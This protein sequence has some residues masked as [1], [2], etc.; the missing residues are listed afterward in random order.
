MESGQPSPRPREILFLG[1][2]VTTHHRPD[3]FH[4]MMRLPWAERNLRMKFTTDLTDLNPATLGAYDALFIYGNA[5]FLTTA[6]QE[7]AMEQFAN[8]GGGVAAMH[9]ACWSSPSSGK[10]TAIIGGEFLGHYAIQEFSQVI[11][12]VDHPILKGLGT[13]TSVD[14]PYQFK[15]VSPDRTI[16]TLRL[17]PGPETEMTWVRHQGQG[18][19]FYHSGGHDEQT[20]VQPNFQELVTRGIEWVVKPGDGPEISALGKA[21]IGNNGAVAVRATLA[22]TPERSAIFTRSGNRWFRPLLAGETPYETGSGSHTPGTDGPLRIGGAAEPLIALHSALTEP[23]GAVRQVLWSGRGGLPRIAAREAG[24]LSENGVALTVGTPPPG[25]AP[26]LVMNDS[27]VSVAPVFVVR[28]NEPN[29]DTVL[30]RKSGTAA[31][32]V[33]LSEGQDL[34]AEDFPWPCGDLRDVRLSL[35]GA[36]LLAARVHG[37]GGGGRI[38]T[39]SD[40]NWSTALATGTAIGGGDPVAE[41]REVRLNDAGTLAVTAALESPGGISGAILRRMAGDWEIVLRDGPQP[42]LPAGESLELPADGGSC[43]IDP[44]SNL[45][46][47]ADIAGPGGS[48]RALIHLPADGGPKLVCRTG[49]TIQPGGE[50]ITA[51]G[52]PETWTCGPAGIACGELTVSPPDG[53]DR[54]ILMRWRGRHALPLI[55]C[56]KPISTAAGEVAV[57]DFQV[58]GGGTAEDGKGGYLTYGGRWVIGTVSPDGKR[59]LIHGD[60]IHDLDGDGRDDWLEDALGGDP[61]KADGGNPLSGISGEPVGP[62][63]RFL[64]KTGAPL[65][66]SVEVSEDLETW[67]PAPAGPVESGDQTGVPA[68]YRRMELL[69]TDPGRFARVKVTAD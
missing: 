26:E 1:R 17:G 13:Y 23:G 35:N 32:E 8:A 6:A 62:R 14:E 29:L 52:A 48:S 11:L 59:R 19:V 10:I 30:V 68:G 42:W 27:G 3:L 37:A 5:F 45:W 47:L 34:G 44:G 57:A 2:Q 56:G 21:R 49:T 54:K 64:T 4:A 31:T 41:L 53:P 60:A 43:W 18:R 15:N 12:D 33:I 28:A 69:L 40:E 20:W 63:F 16:L 58:D 61:S 9:V 55:E 51:L 46:T 22:G 36:G 25:W 66:Y 65:V 24:S 7:N 50:T 39:R 38:V 67:T